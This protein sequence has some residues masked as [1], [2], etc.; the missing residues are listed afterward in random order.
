MNYHRWVSEGISRRHLRVGFWA[1]GVFVLLGALLEGLHATKSGFYLDEG[2]ETRRLL[3]RLSHAHGTLLALVNVVYGLTVDRRPEAASALASRCLLAALILLPLG[4][5]AG[6]IDA[7][8]GDPGLGAA[9]IPAGAL[10]LV[11]GVVKIA[12]SL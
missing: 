10:A 1:L 8:G 5:F 2:N 4:F 9:L 12:R 3:W 7:R 6:G 11:I